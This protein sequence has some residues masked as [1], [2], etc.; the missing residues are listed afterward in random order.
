MSFV[1]NAF[2]IAGLRKDDGK[3]DE[4]D[5]KNVGGQV[6]G[7][8]EEANAAVGFHEHGEHDQSAD[9]TRCA[10]GEVVFV[11]ESEGERVKRASN[12]GDEEN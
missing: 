1:R 12:D 7:N 3:P 2:A 10:H 9:A 8:E 11:F 4:D 5:A 6:D